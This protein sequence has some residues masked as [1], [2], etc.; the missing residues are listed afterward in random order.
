MI[1]FTIQQQDKNSSARCGTMQLNHGS[2]ATP[3][4]MPVGTNG[5]V[6]ALHHDVIDTLGY[7][8]I[9]ANTY[10]LYL[11]P[12]IEIIKAA[13]GLH[14]FASWNTNILTDS[15]G[16]QIFSLSDMRKIQDSGVS[17]KSH[18]DGSSHFLTPTDVIDLQL[19]FG[20]DIM[21]PLAVCT[22]PYIEYRH[23]VEALRLTTAWAQTAYRRWN[24]FSGE[25]G[26][27]FGIIQG[28]FHK[29]LRRQSAHEISTIGFPGLAIGGLSVGEE[30]SVFCDYLGY[31]AE[32]LPEELPHYVMGIG[33]PDYILHAIEYGID[34]FDCV[35]AT[36]IARNGTVFTNEGILSLK[37]EEFSKDFRPILP[38][39]TCRTCRNF[40]R[41]YLRHL[42]K[43]KEILGPMLTTEHNLF[44]LQNLMQNIRNAIVEGKF[45]KFKNTFLRNYHGT[46]RK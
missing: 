40:T 27:L 42:F 28:N 38:G 43:T 12:G 26:A 21:M 23:A 18:I 30:K 19:G 46:N 10:H 16:Y 8:I 31:T 36:R 2:V 33:T 45:L 14:R 11:R 34:I 1:T 29:D 25:K 3:A 37:K 13:G 20:S 35:F 7:E 9:L 4:F 5:T 24:E 32:L 6:K 44:F 39:C 17:F 41:A 15:G 22:E